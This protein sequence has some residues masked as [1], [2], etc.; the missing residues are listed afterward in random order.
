MNDTR[1][2]SG[3]ADRPAD[4][5][6]GG[7]AASPR[8]GTRTV[9]IVAAVVVVEAVALFIVVRSMGGKPEH[10]A[11]VE[12]SRP[13]TEPAAVQVEIPIAQVRALNVRSGR[14]VLYSARVAVRLPR[15]RATQSSQVLESKRV[16]VEDAVAR[17]IREAAPANLAEAGF[18]ELRR[19][20]RTEL[21]R[22]TGD[23]VEISE[24]IISECR[25]YPSEF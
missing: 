25:P 21:N 6:A 14:P 5:A 1:S 19:T 10:A 12:P 11:A 8:R 23:G 13:A 17:A 7:T 24:V 16:A 20:I 4:E 18:G 22:I 15:Q 9:A 3:A 2:R